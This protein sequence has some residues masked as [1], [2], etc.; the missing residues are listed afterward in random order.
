MELFTKLNLECQYDV[1]LPEELVENPERYIKNSCVLLKDYT[2]G[3][4]QTISPRSNIQTPLLEV[5]SNIV[6]YLN[7][8]LMNST[9]VSGVKVNNADE[10]AQVA[11]ASA[12]LQGASLNGEKWI[13][14]KGQ[15]DFQDLSNKSVGQVA[16]Y[17]QALQALDNFRLSLYGLE[18]N[19]VFEKKAHTLQSEQSMNSVG[20]TSLVL[21]DGLD[22]RQRFCNIVNS[23]WGI[24]IWCEA[25]EQVM[26]ADI[27]GDG[28]VGGNEG[29]SNNVGT[30]ENEGGSGNANE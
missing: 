23:I 25:T 20:S 14:M 6:P 28:L 5:M 4:A 19:G 7:T 30:N 27:N 3:L 18:N 1:V 15:L 26:G 11:I 29:Y 9:G 17:L 10:A 13:A 16:D 21:K 8:A 2:N 24:G 22:I 12:S